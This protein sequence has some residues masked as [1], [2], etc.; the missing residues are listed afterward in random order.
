MKLRCIAAISAVLALSLLLLVPV[1]ATDAT[2]ADDIILAEYH[3]SLNINAGSSADIKIVLTNV[4]PGGNSANNRLVNV[5][6]TTPKDVTVD[7]TSTG[8]NSFLML[9]GDTK[10]IV[11]SVHVGI[12]ASTGTYDLKIQL[13]LISAVSPGDSAL[14]PETTFTLNINSPLSS[15]DAFNKILGI[16]DNPFPEPFDTPLF[17]AVI[18]FIL[19]ILIGMLLFITIIPIFL[20]L[21]MRDHE[22]EGKD[23]RREIRNFLPLVLILY[24][25]DSSLRVYGAPEELIGNVENWFN[26]F[27]IILGAVIAWRL[28]LVFVKYTSNKLSNNSRLDQ[29]EMDIAP[30]L[31]LLGKL[32]ISV[33]AVALVLSTMGFDL[34]AI[35]TSAGIVSLGI[36]FGAQNILSQFF[37]G[38]VLLIT[39][40]FKSGD[41][42]RVG[43]NEI[44]RVLEVN[45]MN[46]VFE[47]WD[48]E[49]KVIMPNNMVSSSKIS[50]LTGDGLIYRIAVFMTI[51]YGDNL[52]LAKKLMIDAA[53]AH[54]NVVKDGSVDLPS[55]RVMA[56]LDSSIQ[57]RVTAYV[58]DFNDSSRIGGDLRESIYKLFNENDISIPFPQMDVHLDTVTPESTRSKKTG[59][60]KSDA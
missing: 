53:M 37:S 4:L 18:T 51:A 44:Y 55:T 45:V 19:W 39:R 12:Y 24:A 23:L 30:L 9:G 15:G 56:F 60:T 48:N 7:V 3:D 34:A 14:T 22:E 8:G 1:T 6:Y 29:K 38:M 20:Y 58:Y 26:V 16:F 35:I 43:S 13:E 47:N 42:V 11:L 32:V 41:L 46:T 57:I 2:D 27:Y 49:E 21:V 50:N 10:E 5:M 52:E 28:Y 25:I 36:T 17:T 40:P 54:P 31:R 59:K 33:M